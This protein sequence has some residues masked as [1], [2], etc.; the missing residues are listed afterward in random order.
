MGSF[1]KMSTR[2][3]LLLLLVAQQQG[4]MEASRSFP[5]SREVDDVGERLQS[6]TVEEGRAVQGATK[7]GSMQASDLTTKKKERLNRLERLLLLLKLMK[8]QNKY[9]RFT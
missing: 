4:M 2:A 8:N 9:A 1:G 7:S 3:M 6:S 5:I